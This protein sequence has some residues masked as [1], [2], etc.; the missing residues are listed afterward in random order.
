MEQKYLDIQKEDQ[1]ENFNKRENY[2]EGKEYQP[3]AIPMMIDEPVGQ[4][5][6]SQMNENLKKY[7]SNRKDNYYYSIYEER[8]EPYVADEFITN[9]LNEENQSLNNKVTFLKNVSVK[10][11]IRG[12]AKIKNNSKMNEKIKKY[13]EKKKNKV[14]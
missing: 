9:I 14:S 2:F 1:V 5:S 11:A 13:K 12:L 3:T 6:S 8:K 7:L 10:D 4:L